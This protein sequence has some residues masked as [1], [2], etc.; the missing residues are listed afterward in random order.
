MAWIESHQNIKDHKKTYALMAALKCSKRDAISIVHMLWW[1]CLDNA[2]DG[3]IEVPSVAIKTATEWETDGDEL[4]DA[5]VES[6]WLE[7]SIDGVLKVHDWHHYCGS[8]VEKRL[9]RKHFREKK[10]DSKR[11][12]NG[13]RTAPKKRPTVSVSVSLPYPN[14]ENKDNYKD[15]GDKKIAVP[16]DVKNPISK[17]LT[18]QAEFVESFKKTYEGMTGQPYLTKKEH[19]VIVTNLIKNHGMDAL[20]EKTR[21][22]GEL[23]RDGTTWFTKEGWGAFSIEKLS[24]RWNEILPKVDKNGADEL[25]QELKKQEVKRAE[26]ERLMAGTRKTPGW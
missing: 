12:P 6:G 20:V 15:T 19:F 26:S 17:P 8:L 24:S 9:I 7:R 1:W 23:C 3:I 2:L 13:S 25:K 5:L 21:I 11:L 14:Q 16:Q 10:A 22:L 18:P 4:V